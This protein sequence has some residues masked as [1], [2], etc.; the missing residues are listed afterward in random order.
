MNYLMRWTSCPDI[1]SRDSG[2]ATSR[3][4]GEPAGRPTSVSEFCVSSME[5]DAVIKG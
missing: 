4:L 2:A 1:E 3:S 5:T